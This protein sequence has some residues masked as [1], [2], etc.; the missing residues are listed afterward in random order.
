MEKGHIM[1]KKRIYILATGGTIAGRAASETATT[2]YQAGAIGIEELLQAVPELKEFAEVQGEQLAALDSKDMTADVWLHLAN[3][4]EELL[5]NDEIDGIVITHGTDTMEETG[6]FL[7]LAVHSDK[8][9]V[10]TGAMR[11][12][13]A[14]SADGPMNLLQAVRVAVSD[15]SR[16]KGVLIVMNG[17]IESAR[18]A[19]KTHTTSLDTFQSPDMGALGTVQD[20]EPIFYR[21]PLRRH[22]KAS[23]FSVQGIA[24]LPRVAILYAHADDDGFLVDAAVQGGVKGIVYAG[25]GNGSIPVRVEKE[26]AEAVRKGVIVVRSTRSAAG[27]VTKAETSYEEHGFIGSDT[28]NPQKARILLQLALL[29]TTDKEEIRK[30]YSIY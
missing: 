26:L 25:M 19:V 30:F 16:G 7:H 6:Y 2:G 29:Q 24:S 18:E 1:T 14:V 28:L 4:C 13:T 5:A 17:T 15:E 3:R 8:P 10:L 22:T 9:I 20:G 11:P 21:Q 12:A 27:R 23:A